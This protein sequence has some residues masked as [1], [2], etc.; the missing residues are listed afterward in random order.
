MG[1]NGKENGNYYNG[2]YYTVIVSN[3]IKIKHEFAWSSL[4]LRGHLGHKCDLGNR[5]DSRMPQN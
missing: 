3:R 2:S 1:D 4:K 5:H